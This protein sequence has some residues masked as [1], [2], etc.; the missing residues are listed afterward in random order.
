MRAYGWLWL[1]CLAWLSV[2]GCAEGEDSEGNGGTG[3]LHPPTGGSGAKGGSGG[4][5]ADGGSTGGSGAYAGSGGAAGSAGEAGAS[6]AAGQAGGATGGSGGETGGTGG[7]TGGTGGATGGTGG[8]TGG[9]GGTGGST[10]GTGGATGGTGGSTGGT[11]GSTGGTGGSTGGTGG[12]TGGT[13]G[14]GGATTYSHTITIDGTNDFAAEETF[15]TTTSSFQG[16]IAW[17]A[18]NLYVG[19]SGSDVGQASP[20]VFFVVYLGGS[21]GTTTG[22]T[23]QSQTPQLPFEA[24]WQVHWKANN[25]NTRA[26]QWNGSAWVDDSWD[27]TGKIYQK[28]SFVEMAIPLSRIG[29]PS[30]LAVA[31]A[32]LNESSSGEWTWAGVPKGMFVDGKDPDFTKYFNFALAGSTPPNAHS[33]LPAP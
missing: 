28:G 29:S 10:G 19:L 18:N 33:I 4:A 8:S 20:T 3:A 24:K 25:S 23:Y 6:G 30:T 13:G 9:T 15:E 12:A 5:E 16:F 27:F 31:M 1:P 7:A 22:V 21:G 11:G 32:M 17:D 2:M 26:V 14:T